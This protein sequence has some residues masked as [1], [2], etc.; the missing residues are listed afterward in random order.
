MYLAEDKH[1]WYAGLRDILEHDVRQ[2]IQNH[3]AVRILDAG[4][5]T[6]G[7]LRM[8][9]GVSTSYGF[10][11]SDEALAFT[12]KRG[13]QNIA[14]ASIMQI[15]FKND[16]FHIV[17]TTDVLYHKW[18]PDDLAAL[19][20]LHRVL[21]P[22]GT[23]LLHTAAFEFLRGDHDKVVFTR[24]R[25]TA[26]ELRKQLRSAGFHVSRMTYRNSLLAPVILAH[27]LFSTMSNASTENSDIKMPSPIIN[28]L[29]T[30]VLLLE[31]LMLRQF[32]F[33]FGTSLYCAATKPV[34]Q[35]GEA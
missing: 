6:G 23:L 10:D 17:L 32:S 2:A 34:K 1:W 33:P 8:L 4:C 26:A 9:A 12:S 25:Y 16:A 20:E 5:G 15:P 14:R 11:M 22:G 27:R 30:W 21:K 24:H 19:R 3:P 31:N 7:D 18:I 13:Q 29:L 35:P 28:R